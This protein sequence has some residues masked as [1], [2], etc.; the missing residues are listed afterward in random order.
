MI[1][2][3]LAELGY[4]HHASTQYYGPVTADAVEAFQAEHNSSQTGTVDSKTLKAIQVAVRKNNTNN[5]IQSSDNSA[6]QD[7]ANSS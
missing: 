5:L 3:Q 6:L 7:N 1:Q 2:E 4:F